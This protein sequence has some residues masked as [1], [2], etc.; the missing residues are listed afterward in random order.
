LLYIIVRR[1]SVKSGRKAWG[2]SRQKYPRVVEGCAFLSARANSSIPLNS[3]YMSR[4]NSTVSSSN[5]Q[6]I[7]NNALKEYEKRTK[8]DLLA[9][10]LASQLQAC[11][12]PSAIL[13]VLHQQVQGP[14]QAR[15][16]DD[17]WTKWLDPTVNILYALCD[18]LGEGVGLVC[19]KT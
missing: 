10:P 8:Q 11:D 4:S 18:T 15:R 3:A 12:S 17:R 2:N 7:I 6:L 1:N 9:H 5:F 14:D 19:L 16:N 13:N